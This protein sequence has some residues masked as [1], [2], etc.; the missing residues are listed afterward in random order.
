MTRL[1][2]VRHGQS[3]ANID[4]Y[5][6]GHVNCSLTDTG[7]HQARLTAEY[8]ASEFTPDKVYA[9]DLERAFSTGKI[10]ADKCD[11]EIIPD[12][13]LREIYAGEWQGS[14]FDQLTQKYKDEYDI[15]LKDIGNAATDGGESVRELFTRIEETIHKIAKEN[16]G[17]TLV[18]ATHATPIR[19]IMCIAQG[20]PVSKM[21]T[22]PWVSNASV[23][24]VD[25]ENGKLKLVESDYHNHL[26]NMKST[27]PSNV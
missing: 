9:S 17:K 19:V 7:L 24:T 22:V 1:I 18:I 16:D 21:N 3:T 6:A 5:F 2:F 20:L 26:G 27:F 25:Y 12:K 11:I 8:I 14:T 4:G 10:I 13:G 23:T 15:W